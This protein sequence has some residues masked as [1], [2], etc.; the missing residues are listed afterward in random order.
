MAPD[1]FQHLLAQSVEAVRQAVGLSVD[2]GIT[3]QILV[4]GG[5]KKGVVFFPQIRQVGGGQPRAPQRG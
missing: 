5:R 1:P 3:R 2:Q 4:A